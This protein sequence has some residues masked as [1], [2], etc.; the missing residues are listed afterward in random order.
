MREFSMKVTFRLGGERDPGRICH[1]LGEFLARFEND[2]KL[3]SFKNESMPGRIFNRENR[4]AESFARNFPGEFSAR[5]IVQGNFLGRAF[6]AWVTFHGGIFHEVT[7]ISR[8]YLQNDRNLNKNE[9]IFFSTESKDQTIIIPYMVGVFHF[10][11]HRSLRKILSFYP[12][13]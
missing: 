6:Y 3:K 13:S 11:I 10:S 8:L 7:Q 12:N 4:E 5:E 2:Q 9:T 1:G